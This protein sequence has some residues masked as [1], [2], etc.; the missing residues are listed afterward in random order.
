MMAR[1]AIGWYCKLQTIVV[2]SIIEAE[3]MAAIEAVKEIAWIRYILSEFGFGAQ[4]ASTL[5][6]DNQSAISV[7]KNPKHH[8][9]MKHLDLRFYWLRDKVENGMIC[10]DFIST[11]EMIALPSQ[12][13][14][15]RFGFIENKWVSWLSFFSISVFH[16]ILDTQTCSLIGGMLD[17]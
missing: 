12:L 16:F 11:L 9:Q 13:Q 4:S 15:P 8:G 2:L 14:L 5:K 7:S 1:G 3:Y 17:M 6:M 10:S